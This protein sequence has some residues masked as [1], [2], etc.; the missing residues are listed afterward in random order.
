M[1]V[2]VLSSLAKRMAAE[3]AVESGV[4]LAVLGG[5]WWILLHTLAQP[6]AGR[7]LTLIE[8]HTIFGAAVALTGW[9][10]SRQMV[11][12]GRRTLWPMVGVSILV[13]LSLLWITRAV[14]QSDF[15]TTCTDILK[16]EMIEIALP[17]T[18]LPS[19]TVSVCRAGGVAANPYL[20]GTLVRSG[21][22]GDLSWFSWISFAMV[23]TLGALAFRDRRLSRTTIAQYMFDAL[24]LAPSSGQASLVGKPSKDKQVVAC[25]NPT[26]WGELCGQLYP[27]DKPPGPGAWCT[28]CQQQF[29][30]AERTLTFN[31]VSLFTDEIDVLNGLERL[32]TLAWPRGQVP[33]PDARLS[34]QERWVTLGT[35]SVP[36][37]ISAVQALALLHDALDDF[38]A[39]GNDR[40]K[41]AV[42]L[43]KKRASRICAWIWVGHHD[44]RLTFAQPTSAVHFAVG[45]T[46]LRDLVGDDGDALTLQLD[47][48]LLPLEVRTAFNMHTVGSDK[49]ESQNNR[50]HVWVPVSPPAQS[51]GD[52]LW[53]DRIEGDALRTWLSTSR[54]RQAQ[55]K[56]GIE[57]L[58]YLPGPPETD[59]KI[60]IADKAL[61]GTLDLATVARSPYRD[62]VL[63]VRVSGKDGLWQVA[64]SPGDSIA[65]WEWFDWEQI[66]LLRQ[67]ILILVTT[68]GRA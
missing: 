52:G 16:G 39:T 24:R 18:A 46:R 62:D 9:A 44:E 43:A 3:S 32:D 51:K 26:L 36:D 48:G 2:D 21:W 22:E 4:P 6:S 15:S 17:E 31:V 10:M 63:L 60:N 59:A 57:P 38:A 50:V 12:L 41:Q 30:P 58:P 67:R 28:R 33:P 40:V 47:I 14:I 45:P 23:A 55:S 49:V 13:S 53:V 54:V 56:G 25:N 29:N 42:E 66:E 64:R 37:V 65:E 20:P 8:V 68:G 19:G 27:A 11:I 35:F 5:T 34:G 61:P 1:A 7:P